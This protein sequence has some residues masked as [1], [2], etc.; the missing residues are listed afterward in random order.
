MST[1]SIPAAELMNEAPPRPTRSLITLAGTEM[2]ERFS[3]YGLQVILAYYLYYSITDGGLGVPTPV[4]LGIAGSYGG[5]IYLS[6][7]LGAWVADRLFAPR[8]VV[9]VGALLIMAGHI[10]LAFVPSF[11]GLAVGLSLIVIGTGGMKVNTTAMVGDLYPD[12]GPQ[13]DSGYSIYYLGICT[14]AFLGPLLTGALQVSW[15]FHIAFGAAAVGMFLGL[16]QYIWGMRYL[17]ETTRRVANPLPRNHVAMWLLIAIFGVAAIFGTI[18]IGALRLDNISDVV[19]TVIFI[20][21]AIYFVKLLSS[22]RFSSEERRNVRAYIPIW[23]LSLLLW[24]TVFQVFTVFAVYADT[25]VELSLGDLSIPPSYLMTLES[26]LVAG[27]TAALAGFWLTPWASRIP[28]IWKLGAGVIVSALGMMVLV[29]P[30]QNNQGLTFLVVAGGAVF[31]FAMGEAIGAPIGLS[32]T[33]GLA[34]RTAGTQM[35]ALYFLTMAGG[36]TLAG[37]ISQ[38]YTPENESAYFGTVAGTTIL[39]V[40]VLLAMF[41]LLSKRRSADSV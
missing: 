30:P 18:A 8:L 12:G 15:G 25:R 21:A 2:W 1:S 14:G 33:A 35:T 9:L 17:P 6:Q 19:A 3:F 26:L 7:I 23:L 36:A 4:A 38:A 34:P 29:T 24:T 28:S 39:I 41:T 11:L 13:R 22:R 32:L 10:S 40:V 20:C 27:L 31:L 16:L 37:R 5:L